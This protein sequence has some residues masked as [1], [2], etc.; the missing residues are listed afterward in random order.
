MVSLY[1]FTRF[2]HKKYTAIQ[3]TFKTVVYIYVRYMYEVFLTPALS[4]WMV[5]CV[6]IQIKAI[7]QY[8][9]VVQLIMLNK[10]TIL[11]FKYMWL[12]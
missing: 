6:T 2:L 12:V 8:F 4:L 9:H 7:E 3:H 10:V 5:K 11:T 1:I